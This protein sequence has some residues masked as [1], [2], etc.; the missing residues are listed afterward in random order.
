LGPAPAGGRKPFWRSRGFWVYFIAALVLN[1]LITFAFMN[2]PTRVTV[3]YTTFIQQVNAGNVK[4]ITAQGNSIQGNFTKSVTYGSASGTLFQTERPVFASDNLE[5][6]LQQHNVP[7]T[8]TP[9]GSGQ[10]PLLSLIL[11]FGPALVIVAGILYLNRR[12]AAAGPGGILGAFGR[13]QAKLYAPDSGARTTFADVAG[14]DEAK[15]D[16]AEIVDFLKTP[17]KYQRL[18]AQIPHGVLR[19]GPAGH[20]QD[21]AGPGGR[22]RVEPTVLQPLG[23]GIR[24]GDRWGRGGAGPRPLRAGKGRGAEHHLHR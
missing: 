7:I 6:L 9:P 16:L 14:I 18:G 4:S 19:G 2:G 24:R 10:S 22:R 11:G 1:Y 21:V 15:Q 8:A 13:S 3:P 17:E 12:M 23:V 20:R 5:S